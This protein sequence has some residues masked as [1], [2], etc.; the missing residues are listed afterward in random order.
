MSTLRFSRQGE[1]GRRGIVEGAWVEHGRVRMVVPTR[2]PGAARAC[3]R[4][5]RQKTPY[6]GAL[7]TR[8]H[9]LRTQLREYPRRDSNSRPFGPEGTSNRGR[10]GNRRRLRET[11][12]WVGTRGASPPLTQQTR[13][14]ARFRV[15]FKLIRPSHHAMTFL[16]SLLALLLLP[17][18]LSAPIPTPSS[19]RS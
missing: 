14:R 9:G 17:H 3:G 7:T 13:R 11:S 15:K 5:M 16:S 10:P 1:R 8:P 12:G 6:S 19:V 2:F 4:G 18:T